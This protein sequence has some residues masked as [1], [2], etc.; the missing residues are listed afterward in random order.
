MSLDTAKP[1]PHPDGAIRPGRRRGRRRQHRQGRWP[2]QQHHPRHGRDERRRGADPRQRR[3]HQPGAGGRR[4]PGA[5]ANGRHPHRRRRRRLH[6]LVRPGRIC[7]RSGRPARAPCPVP[8]ATASAAKE[9]TVTDAN[10]ALGRLS[11]GGLIGGTHGPG[12]RRRPPRAAKI[13]EPMGFTIEKTAQGILGIVVAN[14]VRAIR[15]ISVERGPRSARL[16]AH[17]LR[18]RRPAA[19]GGSRPRPQHEGDRRAGGARASSA[20]RG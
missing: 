13:A 5:P 14:M 8:P 19:R 9:P 6:R 17:A 15:T 12:R 18:R 3:R 16:C 2:A 11:K 1:V 20:P 7:S 4:L 10:L